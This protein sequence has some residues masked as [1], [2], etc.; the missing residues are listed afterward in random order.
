MVIAMLSLHVNLSISFFKQY[1]D[2]SISNNSNDSSSNSSRSCNNSGSSSTERMID[3][4]PQ[5]QNLLGHDLS[6]PPG[7]TIVII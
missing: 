6:N 1:L 5:S 4:L 2:N 3:G 7:L